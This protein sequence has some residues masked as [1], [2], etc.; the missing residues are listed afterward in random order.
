MESLPSNK[1]CIP[2]IRG[3]A[4]GVEDATHPCDLNA[5]NYETTAR[6]YSSA[7]GYTTSCEASSDD[8]YQAHRNAAAVEKLTMGDE[9]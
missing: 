3:S 9:I 4:P 6:S 2:V 8:S 1:T 5:V 7:Q